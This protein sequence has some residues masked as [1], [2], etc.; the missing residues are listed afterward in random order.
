VGQNAATEESTNRIDSRKEGKYGCGGYPLNWT[1]RYSCF[2]N[3]LV[4]FPSILIFA[5]D[6]PQPKLRVGPL[7]MVHV[8]N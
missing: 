3:P 5:L 4:L 1:I 8:R 7:T 6:F 2:K